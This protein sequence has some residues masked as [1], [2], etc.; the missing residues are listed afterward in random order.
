MNWLDDYIQRIAEETTEKVLKEWIT[1]N[2]ELARRIAAQIE[3]DKTT[4]E[5][6]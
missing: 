6:K 1:K 4:M 5:N 3:K 2:P